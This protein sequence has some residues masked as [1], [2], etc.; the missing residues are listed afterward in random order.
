MYVVTRADLP[1]AVQAV[2]AAHAAVQLAVAN[3]SAHNLADDGALII[4]AARDALSLH[5]LIADLG[6]ARLNFEIFTEPDL[7]Y[8]LTA[9]AFYGAPRL[10]SRYP[11]AFQEDNHVSAHPQDGQPSGG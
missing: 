5:D 8:E 1:V 7:G 3:P 6:H 2:Q 9:V 10:A 4:L 11:L